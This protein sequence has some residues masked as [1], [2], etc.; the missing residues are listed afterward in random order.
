[1]SCRTRNSHQCCH[2]CDKKKRCVFTVSLQSCH[3]RLFDCRNNN[4]PKARIGFQTRSLTCA[5]CTTI[6]CRVCF[7]F[8]KMLGGMVGGWL[9]GW[10]VGCLVELDDGYCA[11]EWN[12]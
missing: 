6:A 10:L 11:F 1:M 7:I 4:S 9:A 12:D 3:D 8:K 2:I 5:Y